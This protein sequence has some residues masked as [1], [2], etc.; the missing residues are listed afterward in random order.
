[1]VLEGYPRSLDVEISFSK[2][3]DLQKSGHCGEYLSYMLKNGIS[4]SNMFFWWVSFL[5]K[6]EKS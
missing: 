4:M 3:Y 1:M 6:S 5:K 2:I